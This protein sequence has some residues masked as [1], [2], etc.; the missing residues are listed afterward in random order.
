MGF[1]HDF[2]YGPEPLT[3]PA[4]RSVSP[5]ATVAPPPRISA[6]ATVGSALTI[7]AVFRSVQLIANSVSNLSLD[8]FGRGGAMASA[9]AWVTRP[10]I[11]ISRS[12]WLQQVAASLA[13][14]GN[15]YL[16]VFRSDDRDPT[17][18]IQ[19][20][21]VLDPHR[22]AV[23]DR[24][25]VAF[26]GRDLQA[27]QVR[28]LKFLSLPGEPYG[29]G[30][31]QSAISTLSGALSTRDYQAA[32]FE[33]SG[34]P[35]GVLATDQFLSADQATEFRDRWNSEPAGTVRVLGNGLKYQSI[36][37][38]PKELQFLETAGF[39]V[40]DI[41]RL[42]GLQAQQLLI[43]VEG[44][45]LTYQNLNDSKTAFVRDTLSAYTRPI[46]EALSGLLPRGQEARFNFESGLLR[47]ST[48]ERYETYQI[49]L[50]NGWMTPAEVR[51]I[52]GLP[53]LEGTN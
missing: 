35:S 26:D 4:V 52:E 53:P 49:A 19:A 38:S 17:S 27:H 47:A 23:D 14:R 24:G 28:H 44:S 31:I 36:S 10:D 16:R 15:A 21:A 8:V 41:A 30:P 12:E 42:F 7:P 45:S 5:P 11:K 22:V 13:T 43:G 50:E 32:F 48:K 37:V 1:W 51:A 34:I 6:P 46:E 3:V 20:L 39:Q 40:M 9:P 33:N 29:L 18:A 25:T 2:F